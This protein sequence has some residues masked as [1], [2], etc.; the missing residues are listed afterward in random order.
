MPIRSSSIGGRPGGWA[1][2]RRCRIPPGSGPP[3]Q[4]CVCR[5]LPSRDGP[6]RGG[7]GPRSQ[8]V[9]AVAA[10]LP[11]GAG[12]HMPRQEGSQG[13]LCA[14]FAAL[15]GVAARRA[16]PG[17]E[18][19]LRLRRQART[20]QLK[21]Y[22]IQGPAHMT[23]A[24]RVGLAAMRWPI[25]TCFQEGQQRLGLGDYAGRSWI[26]GHH[27]MTLCLRAHFFRVRQK[28]QLKKKRQP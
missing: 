24:Q 14:D 21:T 9:Q 13:P 3:G 4:R 16:Q 1:T 18:V 17:P 11:A 26:G 5:R 25:E 12:Q 2:V 7:G 6:L 23:R 8:A 22:L 28:L 20:A 27:P 10:P 15:R 19:W